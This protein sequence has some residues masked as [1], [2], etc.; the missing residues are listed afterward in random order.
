[1][2]VARRVRARACGL[3]KRQADD[4]HAARGGARRHAGGSQ[5]LEMAGHPFPPE[6]G[7]LF[8]FLGP[9]AGQF[10]D[11]L[12]EEWPLFQCLTVSGARICAALDAERIAIAR[13]LATEPKVLLLDEITSARDP[14]LVAEVLEPLRALAASGMTML[15]ATHE[16]AFA[17]DVADRICYLEDGRLIEEGTPKRIFGSPRDRRTKEFLR[18]VR[19]ISG[20]RR[21]PGR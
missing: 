17:A 16:M 21:A 14:A 7:G 15:I 5:R 8:Q 11:L 10:L 18:R 1:M 9:H 2:A 4:A 3:R 6:T 19:S 12:Q 13:A 20:G